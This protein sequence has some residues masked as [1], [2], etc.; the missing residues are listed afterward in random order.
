MLQKGGGVYAFY[1]CLVHPVYPQSVR[2]RL[3][4]F[5]G[6]QRGSCRSL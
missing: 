4:D 6:Y 1:W 5:D 2:D 3:P